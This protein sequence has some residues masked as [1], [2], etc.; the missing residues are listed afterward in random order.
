MNALNAA[1]VLVRARAGVQDF[2]LAAS[3]ALR[4]LATASASAGPTLGRTADGA[5][6]DVAY[7]RW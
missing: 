3:E 2:P 4:V 5:A 7:T 1:C 6:L